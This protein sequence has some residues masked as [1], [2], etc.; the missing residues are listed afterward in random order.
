M[1]GHFT[2]PAGLHVALTTR[3][4]HGKFRFVI[5]RGEEV[6]SDTPNKVAFGS[7]EEALDVGRSILMEPFT[8]GVDE[9][10]KRQRKIDEPILADANAER[11][12]Y[13]KLSEAQAAEIGAHRQTNA[14]QLERL[15]TAG[16][17]LEE[18]E[19]DLANARAHRWYAA[20]GGAVLGVVAAAAALSAG[21]VTISP[22]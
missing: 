22:M 17:R 1:S 9:G 13:Q 16:R 3:S 7:E 2:D 18:Q 19:I 11:D 8:V 5:K 12:R 4:Q 20:C 14:D 15:R 10:R 21:L 6:L